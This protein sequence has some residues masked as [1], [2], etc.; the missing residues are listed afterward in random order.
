MG[1][2]W[3]AFDLK[4]R[5]DVALK[6]LRPE[7][8]GDE[9]GRQILRNEVRAARQVMSPNVC[10]VFDLVEVDGRELV[11][12]EYVDGQTLVELM[13]ERGGLSLEEARVVTVF[14]HGDGIPPALRKK[15][16]EPFQRAG[17]E[18]TRD[19]P[20]VGIGLALVKRY[21]EAH[22]ARIVVESEVG[23]GTQVSVRF[24]VG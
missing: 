1:S 16:F 21:A 19:A 23:K 10:R 17:G 12:M 22:N 7:R 6:A 4:L 20:G 5:V 3:R 14:D 11:S 9:R 15:I 8:L 2:V 24:R 18:L 13:R